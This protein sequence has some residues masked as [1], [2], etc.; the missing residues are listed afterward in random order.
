MGRKWKWK[1]WVLL[2]V[3]SLVL[4]AGFWIRYHLGITSLDPFVATVDSLQKEV[5][6]PDGRYTAKLLYRENLA[7]TYGFYHVSIQSNVSDES[8]PDVVEV[9]A[10][11]LTDL[12]WKDSRNL[13]VTFDATKNKDH[14]E[15]TLFAKKPGSWRSIR[16]EYTPKLQSDTGTTSSRLP[17]VP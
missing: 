11:G 5:K 7:M 1:V 8:D 3:A 17:S 9:A 14:L 4:F 16:I 12:E 13:I 2:I 10:E 15:D 6:S